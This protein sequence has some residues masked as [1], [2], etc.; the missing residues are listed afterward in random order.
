MAMAES[1]SPV[2]SD[3]LSS[4]SS[5]DYAVNRFTPESSSSSSGTK[6]GQSFYRDDDEEEDG[7]GEGGG[8][9][10][11][12]L[13]EHRL[14]A[15]LGTTDG[16]EAYELRDMA[17]RSTAGSFG[18][19]SRGSITD[20]DDSQK[21]DDEG[22]ESDIEDLEDGSL[23]YTAEE[24]RAIIRK[25]DRRLVVFVALLYMLSFLDRSSSSHFDFL[26]VRLLHVTAAYSF[27]PCTLESFAPYCAFVVLL[28]SLIPKTGWNAHC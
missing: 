8:A 4:S 5:P 13:L 11:R 22:V 20:D 3:E 16:L 28:N 26:F 1:H 12:D 15:K 6:E 19:S 7:Y 18:R 25:F 24:E 2:G 10:E 9:G 27:L 23:V 17:V 21:D 14:K